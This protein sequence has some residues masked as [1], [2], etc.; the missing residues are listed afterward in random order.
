MSQGIVEILVL[1]IV[2]VLLLNEITKGL[3]ARKITSSNVEHQK[4]THPLWLQ[5]PPHH[6]WVPETIFFQ[7]AP[8]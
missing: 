2:G 1:V 5:S 4:T 6:P 8:Q 3:Q 7:F